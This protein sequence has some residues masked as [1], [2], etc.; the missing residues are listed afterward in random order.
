MIIRKSLGSLFL[1]MVFGFGWP[2][3]AQSYSVIIQGKVLSYDA[4]TVTIEQDQ[5]LK[6]MVPRSQVPAKQDLISGQSYLT[7][8]VSPLD[9]MK[10]NPQ[11][12]K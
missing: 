10:L 9:L 4:S 1:L 12:K 3:H 2:A 8:F 11:L 7:V 6:L 5:G